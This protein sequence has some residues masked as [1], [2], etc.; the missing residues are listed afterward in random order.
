MCVWDSDKFIYLKKHDANYLCIMNRAILMTLDLSGF[1]SLNYT[2]FVTDQQLSLFT[3]SWQVKTALTLSKQNVLFVCSSMNEY[4][5]LSHWSLYINAIL[6]QSCKQLE[7]QACTACCK[8]SDLYLFSECCWLSDHFNRACRN[9]KWHNHVSHCSVWDSENAVKMIDIID[10]D[11]E[12]ES[13][14]QI[15]DSQR[16][17]TAGSTPAEPINID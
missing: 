4:Q 14:Q 7:M 15:E 12:N 9:C 2:L 11:K 6:I 16:L 3:H 10:T 17:L 13:Q 1:Q 8:D 5:I